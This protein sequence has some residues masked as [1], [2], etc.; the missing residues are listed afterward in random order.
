M[1]TLARRSFLSAGITMA[2][3]LSAP[4]L[5]TTRWPSRPIRV[6]VPA[7]TG[8]YDAYI[9]LAVPSRLWWEKE[10]A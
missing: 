10:V 1:R 6:V 2:A 4:A 7:N 9:R 8:S 5:A 3:G